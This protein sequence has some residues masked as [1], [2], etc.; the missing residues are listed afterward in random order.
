MT[1]T[2]TVSE[3]QAQTLKFLRQAERRGMIAVTR[4]GRVAAF[5]ISRAHVEA[6]IE[7]MGILSDPEAMRAIRD[8]EGE[9]TKM[10]S[11]ACLK[12]D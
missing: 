4:H 10:R 11:V 9:K 12:E 1:S 8:F 6:M 5:L 7:T 2:I 3:L